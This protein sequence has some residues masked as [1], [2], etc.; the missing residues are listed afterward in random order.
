MNYFKDKLPIIYRNFIAGNQQGLCEILRCNNKTHFVVSWTY[1][2]LFLS[3][4]M[5]PSHFLVTYRWHRKSHKCKSKF[6]VLNPPLKK[7]ILT[8]ND[9]INNIFAAI[10][11]FVGISMINQFRIAFPVIVKNIHPSIICFFLILSR[12]SESRSP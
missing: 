1:I 6:P 2:S 8:A 5:D 7:F 12:V 9:R 10:H 11:T 3:I 4:Q